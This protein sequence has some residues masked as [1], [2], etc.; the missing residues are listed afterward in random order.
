MGPV[1][2]TRASFQGIIGWTALVAILVSAIPLGANRPAAWLALAAIMGT[3]VLIQFAI[4]LRTPPSEMQNRAVAV[5]TLAFLLALGWAWLQTVPGWAPATWLHPAWQTIDGRGVVAVRPIAAEHHVL[6]LA[7]YAAA[8]WIAL[9]AA[10]DRRRARRFV[11]AI[12]LFSTALAIYGLGAALTGSNPIVEPTDLR[13]GPLTA[14]FVNRNS[15]AT[16]AAFGLLANLTAWVLDM[17]ASTG[18]D[19]SRTPR[20][21]ARDL[22]E[23]FVRR[24]WRFAFGALLCGLA[25]VISQSRAGAGAT[26]LGVL[27]FLWAYSRERGVVG[28]LALGGVLAGV[29]FVATTSAG[30]LTTRLLTTS[31]ETGRFALFPR[32]IDGMQER[33]WLGHGLGGFAD[34]FRPH[35][36]EIL[37]G[38]E[39]DL[40]HN[41]FLENAFELGVPAATAL[42]CALLLIGWRI[43]I[44]ARSRRRDHVLPC[45]GLAVLVTAGTHS[46]VD[47]SLQMPATA[48]LFATLIGIAWTQSFGE[49]ERHPKAVSG[50]ALRHRGVDNPADASLT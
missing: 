40:A 47:F 27:T 17:E 8:F 7:T 44:G 30:G 3:L 9:R 46:L 41:A 26:L 10:E 13:G 14:T 2:S 24:G 31:D 32:I 22:A 34:G 18:R 16:Y 28:K 20:Q 39:W 35:L 25:I 6:R 23:S 36:P 43:L 5:P 33:L 21:L 4:D 29:V 45:L 50:R 37:A 15:Y 49:H 12:A 19:R 42:Y 48:A 1:K 11:V 38:A